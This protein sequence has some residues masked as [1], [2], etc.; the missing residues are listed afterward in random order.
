MS[1]VSPASGTAGTQVTF[2]GSGFGA[3]QGSGNVWL[4]STYG[5][6]VS[7]SDTQVVASI[8]SGAKSGT[9]QILQ[10]GVWSDPISFTVATPVV[11]SVT[12]TSGIAGTQVTFNGTG[13]GAPQGSSN[14]WLGST[15]GTVVSWSDTQ[16]VATVAPGA[17]SGTAQILQGGVWSDPIS[18]TVATPVVS[19]VTPTSGVAGTQVTLV[20][21][22]FGA[23]QGS[24]NVW[25]GSTYGTV[26]SWS[27]TQ[28]VATVAVGAKSG[29]AQILQGGV[30]SDV[31][32][33]SVVTPVVSSVTPTSGV[34]GTQ[35]TFAGTGFGA[36]Q[37]SG[38]VW[39]GSTYGTVVSW[40]DTQVVATVAAGAKSGTAQ[41]LQ[42]GVWSDVVNFSVV[43]P[44]VSSVT[45]TGGIAGTQVT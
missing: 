22:G 8:A 20:G 9:A 37:G 16:V 23:T 17:K 6:V 10:D 26:V 24:G 25:L 2:N 7:W 34:A 28:V 45:P 44:V 40:S 19:S 31:I 42:G 35:V 36:S 32:N 29:T 39:L 15:Y 3:A 12:P 38:N 4:G 21:T 18:F 11:S 33:F 5:S 1:S 13:F 27:D 30:W 43:T 41:I 14:V